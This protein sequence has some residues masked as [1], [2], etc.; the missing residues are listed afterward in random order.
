MGYEDF[1]TYTEV[2]PNNKITITSTKVSW[3]SYNNA[4]E[5]YVYKDYGVDHFD[6][7]FTH[8]FICQYANVTGE[9]IIAR[10]LLANA[11]DDYWDLFDANEDSMDF[12]SVTGEWQLEI[13]ES[14]SQSYDH[15]SFGSSPGTDYY[16][17]IDRD[18][19][20]GANGT[21]QLT[22]EIR[23]GSHTGTLQETLTVDSGAGE[24]NDFR[25]LYS[26]NTA[27][28]AD[29]GS[30]EDGYTQNLDLAVE[31]NIRFYSNGNVSCTGIIDETHNHFRLINNGNIE[32]SEFD[33]ITIT[34][35]KQRIYSDGRF[36][37]AG[38]LTEA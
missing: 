35:P 33:E 2:D 30:Y 15:E 14:G 11:I 16:V 1:T 26:A 31:T 38:E 17:T 20:G 21:G 3:A 27:N 22:A 34:N 8:Q 5:A 19:D 12:I 37:I 28:W 7:D 10:W 32:C 18:D 23:T 25:Y 24:Q 6:G 13:M 36:H 4:E 9:P 29:S